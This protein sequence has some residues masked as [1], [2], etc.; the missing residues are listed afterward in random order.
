MR[1]PQSQSGGGAVSGRSAHQSRSIPDKLVEPEA[2]GREF[3][4]GSR[5]VDGV[6]M[7]RRLSLLVNGCNEALQDR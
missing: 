1:H 2:A 5:H 7:G 6:K 3:W 4:H